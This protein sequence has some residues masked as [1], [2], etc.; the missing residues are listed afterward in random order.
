MQVQ[1]Q[2]CQD[3]DNPVAPVDGRPVTKDAFPKL[4]VSDSVTEA[5]R[6]LFSSF[7]LR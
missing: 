5:H 2:I 6:V 4:R 3:N 7:L 1:Y